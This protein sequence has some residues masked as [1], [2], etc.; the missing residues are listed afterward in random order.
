MEELGDWKRTHYSADIRPEM[1]GSTVIVMGWVRAV[2]LVGKLTFIQLADRDGFVQL[3]I[4]PKDAPEELAKKLSAVSRETVLAVK[5]TVKA[6][7]EAPG[8]FE[9]LP[10][11]AKILNEAEA[12]LPMEVVTKKTP[13]EFATRLDARFVDLRRPEVA[14]IFKIKDGV[15]TGIRGFLESN[16][17]IEIH[18]PKIIA[19]ASEG[20]AEV[21]KVK[22]YDREAYLAQSPQF[23]K[24]MLMA[25]GFD[26]VYEIAPAFRAEKSHTTRH[27]SEI[28]MLD[29][30]MA[31]ISSVED[32]MDVVERMMIF[33][34]SFVAKNETKELKILGKSIAVPKA[35]FPRITMAEARK[36]LA[37]RGLKYGPDEEIDSAGEKALGEYVKEKYGHEFVFL[38]EFPWSRAKFY[39]MQDSRNPKVAER[40]DLI[41]N[42]SEIATVTRREH[43]YDRL[44][45]QARN[46][47]ISLEKIRFY[48]NAFRYGMPPHGGC[49]VGVERIVQQMLGLQTVQEAVLFPRTPERLT[50]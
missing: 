18:S 48:L 31:F 25:A 5:G 20:G 28:L 37:K 46:S 16:G 38:T 43:R 8:G 34:C 12:P 32:V 47:G 33:V 49:G 36:I 41:Y 14:A 1:D 10:R 30:E 21:F 39:H 22:Y 7:K 6:S 9:I 4:K 15:T 11:E 17:F 23:Y 45:A 40:C 44:V 19:E 26:R 2:R 42:G 13:A 29:M 50:P 27:V 24:Q 35:P 3:I